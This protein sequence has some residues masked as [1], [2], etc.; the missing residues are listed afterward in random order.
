[1]ASTPTLAYTQIN[2]SE[3]DIQARSII[4]R[5][6]LI[7]VSE[8]KGQAVL[9]PDGERAVVQYGLVDEQGEVTEIGQQLL[10]SQQG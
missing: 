4:E 10:D 7:R 5:L 2:K 9:S 3:A 8:L 1:M 6:G